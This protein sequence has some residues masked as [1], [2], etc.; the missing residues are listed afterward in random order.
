ME[1][2]SGRNR[3]WPTFKTPSRYLVRLRTNI[4]VYTRLG[5]SG[6][7]SRY[8][9]CLL[10]G[11]SEDRIPVGGRDFPHPPLGPTSEAKERVQVYI[12]PRLG[13]CGLFQGKIYLFNHVQTRSF[14][15]L[16]QCDQPPLASFSLIDILSERVLEFCL[17][18]YC[19]LYRGADKSLAR[20]TSRC[21]LFDGETIS[22]DASLVLYIYN[23][24][25]PPIMITN[26]IYE[27]KNLLSLQLVSFLVGLRTYQQPCIRVD[28]GATQCL[29]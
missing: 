6:Q 9:D 13:L 21:I 12:Y 26:S 8:S 18:T 15:T 2:G 16:C 5:G 3:P 17:G 4:E 10:A 27:L 1:R 24:N 23:T 7:L 22:F 28:G 29:Q 25:I 20:P 14:S 11:Q 19:R